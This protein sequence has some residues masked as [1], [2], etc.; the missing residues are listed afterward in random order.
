VA[1]RKRKKK[2]R[3]GSLRSLAD[4][5]DGAYP[6]RKEDKG[7]IRT[8]SWWEKAVSRRIA[9]VARPIKLAH[10]TLLIHTQSSSWAQEL[11]FHE[12]DLLAS[13]RQVSPKVKRIRI[14][15]GPM[16][17]PG[18]APEPPP[19]KIRPLAMHELPGDVAR[20]LAHL[21]DDEVR[22]AVRLA[23]CTSLGSPEKSG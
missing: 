3:N 19:P 10:G 23:A 2:W 13:V 9:E 8:F 11:S 6:G 1:R 12:E 18:Q 5:L 20:A 15:V 16:P 4:I 22:D 14:R 7:L 17:P 21:A